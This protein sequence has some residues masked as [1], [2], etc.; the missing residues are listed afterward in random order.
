MVPGTQSQDGVLTRVADV[1]LDEITHVLLICTATRVSILAISRPSA[2]EIN[3]HGCNMSADLPTAMLQIEG[4]ASGRIFMRGD[5]KDLYELQY[6]S[7][8]TGWFWGNGSRV[9]VINR[10]SGGWTNAITPAILSSRRESTL[11]SRSM[12][13]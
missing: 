6:Q 9:N 4:T 13:G 2:R 11:L 7:E 10:T 12:R 1:F 5:N 8:A 3:L